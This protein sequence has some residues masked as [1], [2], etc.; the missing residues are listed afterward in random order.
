LQAHALIEYRP[1]RNNNPPEILRLWQTAGL[2]RGAASGITA[3]QF[4]DLTFA[5]PYFDPNGLILAWDGSQ[6]VGYVHAGFKVDVSQRELCR[7]EGSICAVIVS[8]EHRRQGIGRRLVQLAE[9]YLQDAGAAAIHAGSAPPCD[10][11]YF[12]LYGGSRPA[13][14][15]ESDA[16]A[17]P[18]F[19]ALGYQPSGKHLVL[20][21]IISG[22]SDPIGLRMMSIRRATQLAILESSTP[23]PWWW[24]TRPGRLDTLQIGLLPK[25]G[26]APFAE[27]TIVGLELYTKRW[28]A[29][30]IGLIDLQV[31][32]EHRRK[33]Y[34]QALIVEV[35]KR[36]REEGYGL[37]EAHAAEHDLASLAVLKSAGFQQVDTGIVY[38]RV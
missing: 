15:L 37:I 18:F 2:G 14:F 11:F 31:A 8:P 21:R 38:R 25:S 13:G 33:G 17:S 22:G 32:A 1:F 29:R 5:Q 3:D 36:F 27:V 34:G 28:Q 6:A 4:D 16:N 35:G 26:G 7:T 30:S 20:Q 23:K 9:D 12:G 24:Q 19:Q 10:P